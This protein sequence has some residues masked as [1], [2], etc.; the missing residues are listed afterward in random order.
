MC[1]ISRKANDSGSPS[2]PGPTQHN[3]LEKSCRPHFTGSLTACLASVRNRIRTSFP[4]QSRDAVPEAAL[5]LQ[6]E[7]LGEL[8][9]QIPICNPCKGQCHLGR[10]L[11]QGRSQAK[12]GSHLIQL[13]LYKVTLNTLIYNN[14]KFQLFKFIIKSNAHY[15]NTKYVKYN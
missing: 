14:A 4:L 2:P 5:V 8:L 10:G 15:N 12:H 3:W 6:Q 7:G 9:C 13:G 1:G 11:C